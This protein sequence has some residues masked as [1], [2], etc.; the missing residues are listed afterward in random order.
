MRIVKWKNKT[1]W[2]DKD[3]KSLIKLIVKKTGYDLNYLSVFIKRGRTRNY[4]G[5][6]GIAYRKFKGGIIKMFLP[7]YRVFI[8]S[9]ERYVK[10][11]W[12]FDVE[13]FTQVF[14]HELSHLVGLKHKDMIPIPQINVDFVKGLK[15]KKKEGKNKA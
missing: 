11:I 5:V 14:I 2:N 13:Q 1:E 7:K 8:G 10:K 4:T 12:E 3:L 6:K 15:L 9:D